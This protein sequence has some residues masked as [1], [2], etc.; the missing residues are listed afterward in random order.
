MK[1]YNIPDINITYFSKE[2]IVTTSVAPDYTQGIKDL[3]LSLSNRANISY[4][5]IKFTF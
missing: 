3:N 5:I 4:D 2:D 1:K